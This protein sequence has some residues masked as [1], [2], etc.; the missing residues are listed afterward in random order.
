MAKPSFLP[1]PFDMHLLLIPFTTLTFSRFT[2]RLQPTAAPKSR[3]HSPPPIQ[4]RPSAGHHLKPLFSYP[5]C[6]RKQTFFLL[7]FYCRYMLLL[8]AKTA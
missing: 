5:L 8:Q 7:H 3:R 2:R 1:S 6:F 4:I